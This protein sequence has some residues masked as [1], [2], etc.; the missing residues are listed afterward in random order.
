MAVMPLGAILAGVGVPY[1]V[2]GR[3][4]LSGGRSFNPAPLG[5]I[6]VK[7]LFLILL[8]RFVSVRGVVPVVAWASMVLV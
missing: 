1:A 5:A 6:K 8:M 7:V 3:S 4:V 2:F